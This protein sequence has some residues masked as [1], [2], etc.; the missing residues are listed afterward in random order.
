MHMR[1]HPLNP[2][3]CFKKPTANGDKGEGYSG[4]IVKDF[5]FKERRPVF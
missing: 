4:F 1:C 2:H 5:F 3:V